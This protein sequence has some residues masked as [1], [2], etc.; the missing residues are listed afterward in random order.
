[1]QGLIKN[2]CYDCHSHE[3]EYPWYTNIAPLSWWIK[4]HIEN[5]RD[6]LNFSEWGALDERE[7]IHNLEECE[8][9][10]KK[11]WMPL[12]SYARMHKKAQL[13]EQDRKDILSWIQ[14]NY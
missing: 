14:S 9:M 12:G 3:T 11:E 10:I 1:M 7:Q 2:A 8:D 6:N 13:S 4:G 5:G